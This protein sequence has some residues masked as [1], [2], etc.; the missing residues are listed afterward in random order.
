MTLCAK[1]H[2]ALDQM[3]HCRTLLMRMQ[4]ATY[5]KRILTINEQAIPLSVVRQLM[6]PWM[7]NGK[8]TD[9]MDNGVS[10]CFLSLSFTFL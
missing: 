6:S 4:I 1:L 3:S 7:D 5:Q 10:F 8:E 2:T 9:E